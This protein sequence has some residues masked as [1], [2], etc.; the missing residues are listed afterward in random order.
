VCTRLIILIR[1][2]QLRR[3]AMGL[4]FYGGYLRADSV[5]SAKQFLDQIA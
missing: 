2:W 1:L 4:R 5:Y 3:I